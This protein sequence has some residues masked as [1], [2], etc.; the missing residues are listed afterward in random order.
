MNFC[1]DKVRGDERLSYP[2]NSSSLYPDRQPT[3]SHAA[4]PECVTGLRSEYTDYFSEVD[5]E[6]FEINCGIRKDDSNAAFNSCDDHKVIDNERNISWDNQER[7]QQGSLNETEQGRRY[8]K[9][10]SL[11]PFFVEKRFSEERLKTSEDNTKHSEESNSAKFSEYKGNQLYK[12]WL[13]R[14]SEEK[15]LELSDERGLRA[16]HSE[17]RNYRASEERSRRFSEEKTSRFSEERSQ[18]VSSE[19]APRFSSERIL[20]QSRARGESPS[21]ST[22]ASRESSAERATETPATR[23]SGSSPDSSDS[24]YIR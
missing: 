24:D 1:P 21:S 15:V 9:E 13:S 6:V 10:R 19:R 16:W 17:E 11:E 4:V 20:R 12:D 3:S 5:S 14:Y 8:S 7:S 23:G 22:S 18:R 2:A